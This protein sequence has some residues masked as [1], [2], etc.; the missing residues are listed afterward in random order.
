[1][2]V[3]AVQ[4]PVEQAHFDA[5]LFQTF[6]ASAPDA[7][8]DIDKPVAEGASGRPISIAIPVLADA[9]PT[10]APTSAPHHH[11]SDGPPLHGVAPGAAE[12]TASTVLGARFRLMNDH[13]SGLGDNPQDRPPR[14]GL[15]HVA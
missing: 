15:E 14:P 9:H 4:T 6:V 11:H 13:G 8:G 5:E 10:E 1:M 3:L 2:V 12:P 7:P